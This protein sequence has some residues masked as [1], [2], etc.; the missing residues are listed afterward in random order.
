MLADFLL[1]PKQQR[2]LGALVLNPERRFTLS[3]FFELADG[4]R[5]ST[6]AFLKTLSDA[7]VIRVE[8]ERKMPRY[9]VETDHPL[10]PELHQIAVKSFGIK[11]PIEGALAGI[12]DKLRQA[13]I[14]G[15]M[16]AGT[17]GPASDV[18]VMVIGDVRIGRVQRELD[19]A[20]KA[21]GREIHVSVYPQ[22]EW[23]AKRAS[24]PVLESIDLGPKIML[25]VSAATD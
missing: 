20:G 16:A 12:R 21:L 8:L 2:I 5:S 4:G 15:S 14:F 10:Y 19:V 11:E 24:D 9:Q 3:E 18:D 1:T 13:F 23:D 7:G 22:D 25:N 6:Q 17:A